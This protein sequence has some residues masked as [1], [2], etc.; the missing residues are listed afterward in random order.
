MSSWHAFA[1]AASKSRSAPACRER[2]QR[3]HASDTTRKKKAPTKNCQ[4]S[5]RSVG[6]DVTP[7]YG[8][9]LALRGVA[10]GYNYRFACSVM[11]TCYGSACFAVERQG[12][13]YDVATSYF[14]VPSTPPST[15]SYIPPDIHRVLLN[16]ALYMFFLLCVFP[17]LQNVLQANLDGGQLD[18]DANASSNVN[19][20]TGAAFSKPSQIQGMFGLPPDYNCFARV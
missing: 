7:P 10:E 15:F 14:Q 20:S 3:V 18:A 5:T 2:E 1:F 16:G 13:S 8:Q 19:T 4:I 11:F 17:S 9:Q 12:Q 6:Y